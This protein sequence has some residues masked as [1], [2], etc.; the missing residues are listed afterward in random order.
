MPVLVHDKTV[1]GG[2]GAPPSV[3]LSPTLD[4]LALVTGGGVL[5]VVR[6][7]TWQPVAAVAL[8][9]SLCPVRGLAWSPDGALPRCARERAAARGSARSS[10][11]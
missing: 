4:C 1:A 5:L 7:L 8:P 9:A 2:G 3:S 6:W 10:A 11:R